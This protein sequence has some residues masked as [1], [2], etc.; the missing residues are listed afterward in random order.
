MRAFAVESPHAMST[1]ILAAIALLLAGGLALIVAGARAKADRRAL[2][3]QL[4]KPKT[5]A[6]ALEARTGE[7]LSQK[8]AA[9]F[10][11]GEHRQIILTLAKMRI[12]AHL[13]RA[14]FTAV[15]LV[16]AL[17]CGLFA[18]RWAPADM[19]LTLKGAAFFVAG[20]VTWFVPMWF[21]RRKVKQRRQAVGHG[22]ADALE[23]LAICMEAGIA[24]ESSLE[25]VAKELKSSHPEL[26]D[27]LARTWAEISI[28]PNREQA[29]HNFAARINLPSVRSVVSMLTQSFRYGTPLVGGLRIAA[30][31]IR[32]DQITLL[33]EKANRLPA[34]MT[35]PVMLFIMPTI[36]LIVGGPAVIRILAIFGDTGMAR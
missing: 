26:A 17:S 1:F 19:E 5:A 32:L 24:L 34:L 18:L 29:F 30:A 35:I 36:F 31:E 25:R 20:I 14:S 33:E 7:K 23:L 28:L 9:G 21:V 10:S 22:L 27:E 16:L 13:A 2:R 4:V 3:I 12:P 6:K 8:E 15:R 11:E